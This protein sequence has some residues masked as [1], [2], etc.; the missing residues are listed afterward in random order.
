MYSRLAVIEINFRQFIYHLGEFFGH[1]GKLTQKQDDD[2]VRS[3][4]YWT[5]FNSWKLSLFPTICSKTYFYW[6]SNQ[7]NLLDYFLRGRGC[8][9]WP[10]VWHR[11]CWFGEINI[12]MAGQKHHSGCHVSEQRV[13]RLMIDGF[14]E[15]CHLD[16]T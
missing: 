16:I 2:K 13:H 1:F 5:N 7:P 9:W 15:N 6:Y 4:K 14:S 3:K 11:I 8:P 12:D 10:H